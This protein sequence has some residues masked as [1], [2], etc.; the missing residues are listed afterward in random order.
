MIRVVLDSNVYVSAFVFGGNPRAILEMA[1]QGLFEVSIAE[2]IATEV[3]RILTEKLLSPTS[4]CRKQSLTWR[5]LR[6]RAI[7][8]RLH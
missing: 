2:P 7:R 8:H 6:A 3:E 1:E 4:G 5:K